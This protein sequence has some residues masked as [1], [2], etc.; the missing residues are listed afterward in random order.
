M[1]ASPGRRGFIAGAGLALLGAV[2]PGTVKASPKPRDYAAL[3]AIANPFSSL[4]PPTNG[5]VAIEEEGAEGIYSFTG[6]SSWSDKPLMRLR[7]SRPLP[8]PSGGQHFMVVPYRYG[9][10]LEYGGVIEAW[11][12]DFSVHNHRRTSPGGA[13]FWVGNDL[14]T[15][16]L[17]VTAR[18][19]A[20]DYALLAAQKF[21][22]A[23]GGSIRFAVRGPTDGFE[24]RSGPTSDEKVIARLGAS[25]DLVVE[26]SAR[27]GGSIGVGNATSAGRIGT[28]TGKFE[29][30]DASGNSLGFVPIYDNI[31]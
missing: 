9:L 15:G 3:S 5:T 22:G 7:V 24:F 28:P 4:G 2:R 18:T 20:E 26:G 6:Q 23:S 29:I 17:H 30:F 21:G 27:F 10:A 11:C 31:T 16:G 12:A 14:D 25:G 13:R 1:S 19:G 8:D